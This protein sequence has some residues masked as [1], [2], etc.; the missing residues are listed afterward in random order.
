MS[1]AKKPRQKYIRC[2]ER[3]SQYLEKRIETS[4]SDLSYDKAEMNALKWAVDTLKQLFPNQDVT[5]SEE[6]VPD[7]AERA[8][9][10]ST[11]I[12]A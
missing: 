8:D 1:Y 3:R 4:Q 7:E 2:L 11:E 10:A 9:Y 6:S 12:E 5:G